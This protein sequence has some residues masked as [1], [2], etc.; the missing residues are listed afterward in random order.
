MV[1]K[2]L[3]KEYNFFDESFSIRFHMWELQIH[4]VVGLI[5]WQ[6]WEL[7]GIPFL[8]LYDFLPI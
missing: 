1:W 6:N 7:F 2:G 5:I 4:K 8:E 3:F